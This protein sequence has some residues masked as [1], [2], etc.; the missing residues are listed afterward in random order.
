MRSGEW[1]SAG[2]GRYLVR[3]RR[4]ATLHAHD[5]DVGRLARGPWQDYRG[6][7]PTSTALAGVELAKEAST[8]VN[9]LLPDVG[10]RAV[11]AG[12]RTAMFAAGHAALHMGVPL[13][14]ITF[15]YKLEGA[16]AAVSRVLAPLMHAGLQLVPVESTWRATGA[17]WSERDLTIATHW[18]TAHAV[19][20][21]CRS[22]RLEP[23]KIVYLI[24]DFEPDFY[25]KGTESAV[26]ES[27]YR[28][29]FVP[30]VNSKPLH[31]FLVARYPDIMGAAC[32]FRPDLDLD[33]LRAV[34]VRTQSDPVIIGFYGRP[35]KP[36]NAFG[37]GVAA[38]RIA[39]RRLQESGARVQFVSVGEVH[40]TIDLG[41][42][43]T[44]VSLGQLAWHDYFRFLGEVS[45]ML[46]LQMT[47]HPSHPPL[48]VVASGGIAV[49]N[50]IDGSRLGISA[51]LLAVDANPTS[52]AEALLEGTRL[53]QLEHRGFD[54]D[55][56]NGLGR[57]LEQAVIETVDR[58]FGNQQ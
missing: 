43:A 26:A 46:S 38:L 35:S 12:V 2:V 21:A 23:G 22:E 1:F 39:A 8:H 58:I 5:R 41:S 56:V 31:R 6:L 33:A 57:P 29:G 36:R 51:R 18:S 52:L 32:V 20:V 54:A 25:P 47:P 48:D 45:V 7:S 53:A 9:L 28:A 24:Q 37:L 44:L 30:L 3:R 55:F 27:T 19:D 4:L 14:T 42:G 50:D 16:D 40:P 13:R 34:P 11:F 17:R 10:P 49:T 15:G